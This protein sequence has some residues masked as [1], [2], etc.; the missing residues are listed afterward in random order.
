MIHFITA[1][2]VL[3][4]TKIDS[5]KKNQQQQ[6]QFWLCVLFS[7]FVWIFLER[8]YLTPPQWKIPFRISHSEKNK[9]KISLHAVVSGINDLSESSWL[10]LLQ[11]RDVRT[12]LVQTAS[13]YGTYSWAISYWKRKLI[14]QVYEF[15]AYDTSVFHYKISQKQEIFFYLHLERIYFTVLLWHTIERIFRFTNDS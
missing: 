9:G 15:M 11:I 8:V 13:Q 7:S 1:R 2:T 4:T 5:E 12:K 14:T 3:T 6:Q 10:F